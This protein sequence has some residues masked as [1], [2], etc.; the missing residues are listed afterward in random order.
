MDAR[1]MAPGAAFICEWTVPGD[2][3]CPGRAAGKATRPD[4]LSRMSS[5]CSHPNTVHASGMQ[6]GDRLVQQAPVAAAST[7]STMIVTQHQAP[8]TRGRCCAPLFPA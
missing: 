3:R 2:R 8:G 7:V 1:V 4:V 6:V 5:F